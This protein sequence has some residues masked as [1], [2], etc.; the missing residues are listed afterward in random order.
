MSQSANASAGNV[1]PSD[2]EM[3]AAFDAALDAVLAGKAID[4]AALLER[5]PALKDVIGGLD[6]LVTT[7]SA[8]SSASLPVARPERIGPYQIQREL[9]AGSFG[10]V[11]LA[12]DPDVKRRVAIKV[13]NPAH[14][15]KPETVA[16]F[17]REAH[18]NGRLLHP[19]IVQLFD[20]SRQGPPYFL[21]TE[22]VAGVEPRIWCRERSA[23]PQDIA[24]LVARIADAVEY[25][26]RQGVLHRDLKPGNLLIDPQGQ[27]H[28]LD[29]GLARL[30]AYDGTTLAAPTA[31]GHI[32]GSLPY[33][34]PE[35]ASGQSH[36]ADARSDVYSLGV[37][38]YELL[39]GRLPFQGP[40]HALP[41]RVIE[42][43]PPAP[44][45][46]N[47]D[48]PLDL[49]AV[50]LKALAKRP[51][52]RYARAAD[53][54]A[55]LRAFLAGQPVQARRAGWL[56]QIRHFLDRRHLETL[57]QGWTILLLLLGVTIL[58][59]SILC[60]YWEI[61]LK[62]RPARAWLAIFLTKVVQVAIMLVL[63]VRLRPA[64][65]LPVGA[66][67]LP[68]TDA[69]A[70]P[71]PAMTAA[72]RQIWSLVP[73]YYG[74]FLTLVI[75]NFFHDPPIL[76]MAPV[77]TM[78][79][80]MGFATLGATIWGWFYV[81]GA[82]FFLLTFA[83]VFLPSYGFTLLG[84]GWFLCLGIGSMHLQWTK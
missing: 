10:V 38:L 53:L 49:E 26:H 70:S 11:Y 73:G 61:T 36:T 59:G 29:F 34:P 7:S 14:I 69:V 52:D 24:D 63:A 23:S 19:G 39:T 60:N 75:I 31:D 8:G 5:F 80:G 55:D 79:S 16:R 33:M 6:R 1:P 66:S 58:T 57:R 62:Q 32:L 84:V 25:A 3:A 12:Y 15:D 64:E 76:P 82:F 77:L 4:R 28:I 51:Q 35:Q 78:L 18:A 41:A 2:H 20:Y 81:W 48:I 40:A 27:P 42:D 13:L 30:E 46:W 50:C 83:I 9:G 45:Q 68:G 74:S 37:I 72:E 22:Y 65:A 71:R 54:S 43:A 67:S 21:V 17:Q 47:P 56:G 44:R